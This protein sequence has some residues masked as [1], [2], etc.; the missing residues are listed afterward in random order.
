MKAA[1]AAEI[2]HCERPM[3][4]LGGGKAD[5]DDGIDRLFWRKLAVIDR[6]RGFV[7]NDVGDVGTVVTRPACGKRRRKARENL[8]DVCQT[9]LLYP[10]LALLQGTVARG[11]RTKPTRCPMLRRI[12]VVLSAVW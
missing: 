6:K 2:E 10:R 12:S 5:S 9:T 11:S 1:T 8:R 4:H 7:G 3:R